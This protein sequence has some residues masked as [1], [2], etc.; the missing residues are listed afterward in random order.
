MSQCFSKVLVHLHFCFPCKHL[1]MHHILPC[2]HRL[3]TTPSS[4]RHSRVPG[5]GLQAWYG[6]LPRP[7]D[8]RKALW[9]VLG[10][11]RSYESF[12][13]FPVGGAISRVFGFSRA[14]SG[15]IS[16]HFPTSLSLYEVH[17]CAFIVASCVSGVIAALLLPEL[18]S[19][20]GWWALSLCLGSLETQAPLFGVGCPKGSEVHGHLSCVW[21]C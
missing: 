17:L 15:A 16:A 19:S 9:S 7:Q 21:C 10:T 2:I 8:F 12:C 20:L 13:R 3:S 4:C 11:L 5:A 6:A 1:C 14:A 18:L